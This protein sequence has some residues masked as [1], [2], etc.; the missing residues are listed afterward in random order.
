MLL[1]H[2]DIDPENADIANVAA[3][4]KDILKS[5]KQGHHSEGEAKRLRERLAELERIA[6]ERAQAQVN[7]EKS[8]RV[9]FLFTKW[10]QLTISIIL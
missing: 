8:L 5:M 3:E 10:R 9:S 4:V 2:L 7:L 6:E 1:C